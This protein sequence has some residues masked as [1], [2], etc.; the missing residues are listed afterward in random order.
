[1]GFFLNF[2]TGSRQVCGEEKLPLAHAALSFCLTSS[3]LVLDISVDPGGAQGCFFLPHIL[4]VV[5]LFILALLSEK[6]P[7]EIFA[8][9]C[10]LLN[11]KREYFYQVRHWWIENLLLIQRHKLSKEQMLKSLKPLSV[12][13]VS[14]HYSGFAVC[15]MF[16]LP[17]FTSHIGN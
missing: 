1:M 17:L 8:A 7:F 10:Q 4:F 5:K 6:R 11:L 14:W 15:N 13:V 16:L 9:S 12:R 3:V 2:I